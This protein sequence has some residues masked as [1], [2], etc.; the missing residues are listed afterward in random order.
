MTVDIT[1]NSQ[2]ITGKARGDAQIKLLIDGINDLIQA[3][4]IDA[5]EALELNASVLTA[6][7]EWL[8]LIGAKINFPRPY[9]P[10]D[11]FT[12]FGF[13]D[14]GLGFDQGPFATGE[15]ADQPISDTLYRKWLIAK[16]GAL[17]IDG[18]LS[19]LTSVVQAAFNDDSEYI[20]HGNMTM[21]C[22]LEG[23]E[24]TFQEIE[25]IVD[26]NFLPKP[27][28]VRVRLLYNNINN[29]IFGFDGSGYSG[30]DQDPFLT[31]Y[32]L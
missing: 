22:I 24:Y 14:N 3:K 28:G 8:D 13:D 20:D 12:T 15:T 32:W 18:S 1:T 4:L 25:A 10:P 7:G 16:G 19:S 23:G 31:E 21:T 6:E 30:F 26:A 29:D 2:Y 5:A 9:F 27:C 17:I 11:Q